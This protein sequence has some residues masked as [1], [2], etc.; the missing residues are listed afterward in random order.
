[1]QRRRTQ[2]SSLQ[3]GEEYGGN[4]GPCYIWTGQPIGAELGNVEFIIAFVL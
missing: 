4:L 1:M 3:A 2:D